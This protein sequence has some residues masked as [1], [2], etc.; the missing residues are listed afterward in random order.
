[1]TVKL[2]HVMIGQGKWA[3]VPADSPLELRSA[4]LLAGYGLKDAIEI[5]VVP[6]GKESP[7]TANRRLKTEL[8]ELRT[9]ID[10][11]RAGLDAAISKPGSDPLVLHKLKACRA[12]F[13]RRFGPTR[14]I[15]PG[16]E[17]T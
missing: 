1:M 16:A 8:L 9:Q 12:D 15:A 11:F 5:I 2:A 6:K 7:E 10:N 14:L 17:R 3:F 13:N 4:A